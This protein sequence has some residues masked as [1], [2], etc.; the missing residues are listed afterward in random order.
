MKYEE[1]FLYIKRLLAI[2]LGVGDL[3]VSPMDQINLQW[4]AFYHNAHC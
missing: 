2:D 4:A 3:N 1:Y